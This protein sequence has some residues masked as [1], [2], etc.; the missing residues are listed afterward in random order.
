MPLHA[1]CNHETFRVLHSADLDLLTTL[2]AYHAVMGVQAGTADLV[3]WDSP[4]VV[5]EWINGTVFVK[6]RLQ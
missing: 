3:R 2:Q 5:L 6:R 1:W 4:Y